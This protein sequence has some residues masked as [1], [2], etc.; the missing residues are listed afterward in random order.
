MKNLLL[1]IA[2]C[3]ATSPGFAAVFPEISGWTAND[4]VMTFT[5]DTLWEHINGA[6]ETFL[7]Y[8]FQELKT[9]ELCK[10]GTTVAI[11]IYEMGS[12]LDAYGIYRTEM[13]EEAETLS[14]GAQALVSA[15]YQALMVKDLFYIKVDVYDGE[16]DDAAGQSI[17]KAIAA[18]LPGKDGMPKVFSML[19]AKGQVPGSQ[20]F[21]REAFLGVR[22]L[23]HCVSA[24]YEDGAQL[25]AMLPPDGGSLDA[26]WQTLESKW[27]AVGD[28]AGNVLSKKVP[29]R[30]L[31]GVTRT[32]KGIFGITG[33]ADEAALIDSLSRF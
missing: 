14:I 28:N 15:P 24:D 3:L 6:A 26:V 1:S 9:A 31:I 11:G 21:T 5:P 18:A 7:Q 23:T 32:D 33:A 4:E 20:R 25:F 8:G 22:E 12:A 16:I 19:P 30:G 29:Y 10:E 27:K 17:L 2:L 13:P